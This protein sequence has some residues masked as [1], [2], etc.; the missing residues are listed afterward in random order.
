MFVRNRRTGTILYT[1]EIVGDPHN[2]A[3]KSPWKE[4]AMTFYMDRDLTVDVGVWAEFED[5]AQIMFTDC[6]MD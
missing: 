2:F 4:A 6:K 5:C 3:V 1:Q